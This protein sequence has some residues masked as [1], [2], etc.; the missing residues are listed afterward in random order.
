[1]GSYWN[2]KYNHVF[3]ARGTVPSKMS[4]FSVK[5]LILLPIYHKQNMSWFFYKSICLNWKRLFSFHTHFYIFVLDFMNDR[6]LMYF[7]GAYSSMVK[8]CSKACYRTKKKYLNK[9]IIV[10]FPNSPQKANLIT[11]I[12]LIIPY[13][14]IELLLIWFSTI[15][16]FL[17]FPCRLLFFQALPHNVSATETLLKRLLWISWNWLLLGI[18]FCEKNFHFS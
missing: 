1:M 7:H 14:W 5:G 6:S 8:K 12:T 15:F 13:L 4:M 11:E 16:L 18:F 10:E 17:W 3:K 2:I 9:N